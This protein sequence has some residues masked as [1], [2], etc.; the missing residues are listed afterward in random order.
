V[1]GEKLDPLQF[2]APQIPHGL[3]RDRTR[4]SRVGGRQLPTWAMARPKSLLEGYLGFGGNKWQD[5]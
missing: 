1:L 3:A 2:C 5:A 4:A